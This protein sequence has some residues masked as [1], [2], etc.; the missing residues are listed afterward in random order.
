MQA[1][2]GKVTCKKTGKSVRILYSEDRKA[3]LSRE[4]FERMDDD[5]AVLRECYP[6]DLHGYAIVAW[7]RDGG[8]MATYFVGESPAPV[9]ISVLPE[10]LAGA[11][12]R[13]IAIR[14]TRRSDEP[15]DDGTA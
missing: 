4:T 15:A 10:W 12:R 7:D 11:F 9:S 8:Y 14:D 3:R 1:R 5:V 6:D 2:I 13:E